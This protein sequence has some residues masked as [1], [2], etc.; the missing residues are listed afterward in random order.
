MLASLVSNVIRR[1]N[2]RVYQ[3]FVQVVMATRC[4]MLECL[5]PIALPATRLTT[6]SRGT[7]ARIQ[8]LLMKVAVALITVVVPVVIAIPKT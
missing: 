1:A 7:T 8:A 2:T 4:S 6:G 5:A 3:R